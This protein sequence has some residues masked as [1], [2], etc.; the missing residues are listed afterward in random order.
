MDILNVIYEECHSLGSALGFGAFE[1]GVIYFSVFSLIIF[2][3]TDAVKEV[4]DK[5][6]SKKK[7]VKK[8]EEVMVKVKVIK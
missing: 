8:S 5:N 6:K 4:L 7:Q 2:K 3:C 1:G